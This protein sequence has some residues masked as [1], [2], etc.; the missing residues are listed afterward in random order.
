MNDCSTISEPNTGKGYVYNIL[1]IERRGD[2]TDIYTINSDGSE[3]KNLTNNPAHY[4]FPT[5]SRD[6][7]KIAFMSDSVG[8]IEILMMDADG[9]NV[10]SIINNLASA[11]QPQFTPA[12]MEIIFNGGD[13]LFII[14]TSGTSLRRLTDSHFDLF[15]KISP[16]GDRVLF[17]MG[18]GDLMWDIHSIGLDGNDRKR[19]TDDYN[20]WFP[21]FSPDGL[22]ILYE[23]HSKRELVIMNIDGNNKRNVTNSPNIA[24]YDAVYSPNGTRVAYSSHPNDRT[25]IYTI[26]I[27]GSDILR[28]TNNLLV[29]R[30]PKYSPD[31]RLIAFF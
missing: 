19:L 20:E 11:N 9:S 17:Q 22:H 29:D 8:N 25:D 5:Y 3:M 15:P 7:K 31:G 2:P 27:D 13:G 30:Y 16:L 28:L 4:M 26:S 23:S 6:G 18:F 24:E 12:G 21:Q 10:K 1:Y 14:D